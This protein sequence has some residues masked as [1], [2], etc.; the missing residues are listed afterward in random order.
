MKA[1]SQVAAF[2]L[3]NSARRIAA[4]LVISAALA[5]GGPVERP[6]LQ[7]VPRPE[8]GQ[9]GASMKAHVVDAQAAWELGRADPDLDT[10]TLAEL[11]GD[12]ARAAH[13]YELWPTADA[14]YRNAVALDPDDF[15]LNYVFATFLGLRG[16]P[17]EALQRLLMVRDQRPEF[18]PLRVAVL[19]AHLDLGNLEA[20]RQEAEAGIAQAP[21]EPGLHFLYGQVLLSEADWTGA[22]AAF[23][24]TLELDPNTDAAHRGLATAYAALGDAER[25]AHHRGLQ[26]SRRPGIRDDILGALGKES[27]DT[28]RLERRAEAAFRRGNAPV[29]A[30]LLLQAHDMDPERHRINIA[31]AV[32]FN[33]IDQPQRAREVLETHLQRDLDDFSRA[34]GLV[35]LGHAKAR[36]GLENEAIEDY[37][38]ALRLSPGVPNARLNL[39]TLL[40]RRPEAPEDRAEALKLLEQAY[41]QQPSGNAAVH[42]A[43]CRRSAESTASALTTLRAAAADR[44]VPPTDHA[45]LRLAELR[46]ELADESTSSVGLEAALQR[47]EEWFQRT[48][49]VEFLEM[50]I[51]ALAKLGRRD[52]ALTNVD[53]ALQAVVGAGRQDLQLRLEQTQSRIV[54]NLDPRPI[55]PLDA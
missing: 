35:N 38:E 30:S 17:E 47:A 2:E 54:D 33:R 42:L 9:L 46:I 40:C 50:G 23:E 16:Q 7:D 29:A 1:A 15:E 48:R 21:D 39:G 49:R 18:L 51:H 55:D 25:A 53:A 52:A 37:R 28:L 4:P 20:A 27:R 6:P 41:V 11:A 22:I 14:A 36:L 8:T 26:G 45:I 13:L 44:Q 3:A 34:I 5:C 31:L 43:V 19:E 32:A 10:E 12:Y 24:R